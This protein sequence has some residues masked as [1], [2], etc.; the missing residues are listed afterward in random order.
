MP[1]K[2]NSKK[3]ILTAA[4]NK[5]YDNLYKCVAII[6]ESTVLLQEFHVYNF[7]VNTKLKI[8]S[9]LGVKFSFDSGSPLLTC[10]INDNESEKIDGEENYHYY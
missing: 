1:D 5:A 7:A 3:I 6:G 4:E 10:L 2:G 8:S 9:D